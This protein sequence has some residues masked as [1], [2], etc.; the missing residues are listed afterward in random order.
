MVTIQMIGDLN[1]DKPK[2][3]QCSSAGPV[4]AGSVFLGNSPALTFAIAAQNGAGHYL[5]AWQD[6]R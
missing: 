4:R 1:F 5:W 3:Q 6:E 2:K